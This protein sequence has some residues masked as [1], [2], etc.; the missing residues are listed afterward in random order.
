MN[1]VA[2]VERSDAG[3]P[4]CVRQARGRGIAFSDHKSRRLSDRFDPAD[5]MEATLLAAIFR[6]SLGAIL[7]DRLNRPLLSLGVGGGDV[8]LAAF[9]IRE[10][11]GLRA[12]P[13]GSQVRRRFINRYQLRHP[14]AHPMR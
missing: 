2:G 11:T 3:K 13:L 5:C 1:E 14:L 10:Y 6:E 7:T 8:G 12:D 4:Q 9:A